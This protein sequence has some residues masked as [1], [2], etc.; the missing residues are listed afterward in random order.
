M[1]EAVQILIKTSCLKLSI[2]CLL[3]AVVL[4]RKQIH[5]PLKGSSTVN[6][7]HTMPPP[8]QKKARPY[9]PGCNVHGGALPRNNIAVFHLCVIQHLQLT[10]WVLTTSVWLKTW[11]RLGAQRIDSAKLTCALWYMVL[12]ASYSVSTVC[13]QLKAILGCSP[14]FLWPGRP[15]E[16]VW[17]SPVV[18]SEHRPLQT[19]QS[20]GVLCTG[21]WHRG[22]A[23]PRQ[24]AQTPD[25]S[26]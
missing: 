25:P 26:A 12:Y 9:D 13:R 3:L 18:Q 4:K 17:L 15:C 1:G 14:V 2:R 24:K 20:R 6:E 19:N 10:V 16:P 11:L 8:G 21:W 5:P 23:A 7:A 22:L